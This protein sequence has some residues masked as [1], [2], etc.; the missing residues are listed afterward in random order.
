[1]IYADSLF[2]SAGKTRVS[3][4]FRPIPAKR[5]EAGHDP[6][7]PRKKVG[8]SRAKSPVVNSLASD[9]ISEPYEVESAGATSVGR[10]GFDS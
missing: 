1:M 2:T 5:F 10:W 3:T 8:K 9:L 7:L 4:R 6:R